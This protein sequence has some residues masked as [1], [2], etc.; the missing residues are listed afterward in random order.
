MTSL[1]RRPTRA[2]SRHL[3]SSFS[4]AFFAVLALICLSPP[5]VKAE[6]THPEYGTVIGIGTSSN[7]VQITGGILIHLSTQI[8]EQR[9]LSFL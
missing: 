1:A 7:L 3:L 2:Q 5:A 4:L 9:T 8:W 6:E